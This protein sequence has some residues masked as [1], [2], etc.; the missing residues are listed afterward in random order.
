MTMRIL[1]L[2]QY[3]P[4]EVG[5]TQT[6]S[7]EMARNLVRLGH[8]VTV[9]TEV[10][11][12]PSGNIPP[13]YRGKLYERANMDGV[14]VI[15]VWVKTAPEKTLA[16]RMLFY[17][18]YMVGATLA[19]LFLTPGRF[20]LVYASSP[21][22]FVGGAALA[23]SHL[24]RA[25]MVFEV[26]DLWPESA[27][28]LGELGSA[29][30]IRL[31][32]RLE[33]TCYLR[34]RHIVVV[35][36]GIRA[37]LL[38]RGYPAEKL[39]VIP[40]GANID[41]YTPQAL[42]LELRRMWGIEPERFVVLYAGLHGLAHG[43]ETALLAA[44]ELRARP[45]VLFLFV[46]DGPQ[47]AALIERARQM[48]LPNVL[49]HD[50]LPEEKLPAAIAMA[51]V[52]L[53]TRRRLGISQG[54]LPVKM[55]SYMACARPVLL[56]TEGESAELLRRAGAG[57]AVPPEDP[58]TL[59]RAILELQAD[60]ALRAELGRRGRA[61]VEAH[62]SRQGFARQLEQVLLSLLAPGAAQGASKE[63]P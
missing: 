29:C 11:N 47:K 21:P 27:V 61:F 1:Y 32:T 43:L 6:R 57:V 60:H 46:G 40:N 10:P 25:P 22:L 44:D 34:A 37:R 38:E 13:A 54:T 31:A 28:Q 4:P 18:T 50:A 30:A 12:H 35:T 39:T 19:G 63:E 23:L 58:A 16:T 3:F 52:G 9:L 59:A 62:Y 17:L 41:L 55:F 15:R 24:R 14:E 33:E 5:A 20:D 36:E 48:G 8:Q 42:N 49:F 56:S 26:R 2:S 53:D 51:D 45:E 7:Y